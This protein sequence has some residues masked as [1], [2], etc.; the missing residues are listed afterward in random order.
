MSATFGGADLLGHGHVGRP[1]P[2]VEVRIGDGSGADRAGRDRDPRRRT[3]SPATGPTVTAGRTRTAGSRTGDIGYLRR[4]RAVPGRP[5]PR[6]DHRQRVQRLSGRGRG[7][8]RASSPGSRRWPW[9]A[10]PTRVRGSRWSPSSPARASPPR[11]SRTTARAG[12]PSSSGPAVVRV[13]DEL[14][15]GR[16]RQGAEGP[17]ARARS[18][19]RACTAVS[20]L[21]GRGCWCSP[22]TGCHLCDQAL[23]VVAAVC[24]ETGDSVRDPRRRRRPGAAPPLHRPGAGDLRRRRPA[25]LLAGR[26]GAARGPRWPG[27]ADRALMLFDAADPDRA[28]R[29]PGALHLPALDDRPAQGRLALHHPRP[30]WSR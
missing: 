14:P 2:G 28:D 26:P 10:G 30:G 15:R 4:R 17:A 11:R 7:G 8:D 6:V 29:G 25:R 27:A 24:A 22:A 13:V 16:D 23:E 20:R 3:C 12:W 19:R 9:S 5:G 18:A 1:L 21:S